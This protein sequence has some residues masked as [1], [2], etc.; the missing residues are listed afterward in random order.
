[1]NISREW[2]MPNHQTFKVKPI[3]VFIRKHIPSFEELKGIIIDPFAHRPSEYRAVTNDIN[4][5]S[6]VQY[7]LDALDFLKLYDDNSIGVVL[8]DPPYS[9]RQLKE[10]YDD[11]G[12]SLHDAKSSVWSNWKE[13]IARVVSPGGIVLSFGWNTVGIGKSRGFE[14]EDILLVSHGGMHND[15]ICMKE[16]KL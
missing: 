2:A 5:K 13:E 16:R 10:C 7:H 9:P 3:D 15:T 8:F 1:M 4:P 12:Q 11:M 14:I 6:N